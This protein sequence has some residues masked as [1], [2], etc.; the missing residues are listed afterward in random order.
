VVVAVIGVVGL[1]VAGVYAAHDSPPKR[2]HLAVR[3]TPSWTLEA[4]PGDAVATSTPRRRVRAATEAA[5]VSPDEVVT[6]EQLRVANHTPCPSTPRSI[7]NVRD[8]GG[9]GDGIADDTKAIQRANNAVAP[10]GGRV[11]FPAGVYRAYNVQQDSCVDFR[12]QSGATLIHP[13]GTSPGHVIKGRVRTTTGSIGRR[14]RVLTV[15][16]TGGIRRGAV[17]AIRGAGGRSRV[18]RTSLSVAAPPYVN[19]ISLRSTNGLNTKWTNYLFLENEIISY[20]GV[21]GNSLNNVR[22]GLFGTEQVHHRAGTVVAQAQR[23]YAVVVEVSGKRVILDSLSWSAARNVEVD[24]GSV[25]MSITNLTIDGNR[26]PSGSAAT[27]PFPLKYML[28]RWVSVRGATVRHGDHGAISFE[29]G[30]R[31]SI[32][33]SSVLSDNGDPVHRLGAAIWLFDGATRNVVRNN[34]IN[35]RTFIGVVVDDRSVESTE[36]DADS[37]RNTIEGNTIDIASF[38]TLMNSGVLVTGSSR[39]VVRSNRFLHS[40]TGVMVAQWT[41][42][43]VVSPAVLNSVIANDF[44]T[45]KV[46]IVVSGSDNEFVRNHIRNAD[47]PLD[48]SGRR[49]RFIDNTVE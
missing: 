16:N 25:G 20:K 28:A 5:Q 35:G 12:G 7:V 17:V 48:N 37:S 32:I 30:T 8:F 36:Y 2:R 47:K 43:T 1:T 21:T 22:R 24:I 49:N 13:D 4:D 34:T 26:K 15:A 23:M 39:N 27:N 42:G 6:T 14:S 19:S 31:D 41:Q 29:V 44:D 45:H 9:R 3:E 33:E 10:T 18:Q 11:I 46:G 40:S 38:G